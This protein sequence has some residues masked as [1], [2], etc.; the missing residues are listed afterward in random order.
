[1]RNHYD[2]KICQHKTDTLN[3]L[4]TMKQM[5]FV[6]NSLLKAN[7]QPTCIYW[8]MLPSILRMHIIFAQSFSEYRRKPFPT[9]LMSYHYE[10]QTKHRHGGGEKKENL[11]TKIFS[12]Y[13]SGCVAQ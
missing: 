2:N 7:L 6:M 13:C 1:M 11:D 10:T 12:K 3:K 8:K 4:I 9:Q 5:K